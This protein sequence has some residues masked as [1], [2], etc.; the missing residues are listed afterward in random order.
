MLLADDWRGSVTCHVGYC[1]TCQNI[2]ITLPAHG[3]VPL[4]R[5]LSPLTGLW[6]NE[7][8][9]YLAHIDQTKSF[10]DRQ[11]KTFIIETSKKN[12]EFI[13][14]NLHNIATLQ[15]DADFS[16]VHLTQITYW[17]DCFN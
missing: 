6:R 10:I 13:N 5:R 11:E 15:R 9:L 8:K 17:A 14:I 3:R 1:V 16:S 7:E 12:L 2:S 4:T